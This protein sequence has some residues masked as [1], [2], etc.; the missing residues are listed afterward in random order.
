MSSGLGGAKAYIRNR[1]YPLYFMKLFIL[2]SV[3]VVPYDPKLQWQFA[4]KYN[5]YDEN[6]SGMIDKVIEMF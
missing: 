6:T 5:L 4:D 3:L 2:N 1:K